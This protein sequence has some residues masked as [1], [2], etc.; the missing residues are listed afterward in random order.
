MQDN[1]TKLYTSSAWDD[2][3]GGD[4]MECLIDYSDVNIQYGTYVRG[5]IS[6][7]TNH[8]GSATDIEPSSG[9]WVTPFII[10]PVDPSVIYAGYE[11]I[12]KTTDRGNSWSTISSFSSGNFDAMAIAPSNNQVLY[13]STGSNIWVTVDG[14]S[15]WTNINSTLPLGSSNI[16]YIAV[17]GDDQN[18][19][20]VSLS[21]YNN[22]NVYE[23]TDGGSSWTNIS[24]GLPGIPAYSIVQNTQSTGEVQLY[25]GTELGVYFKKG[26]DN[27]VEFNTGLP[28]VKIGELEIFYDAIALNSKLYAATY[29][30]GLWVT[31]VEEPNND[32]ASITTS[33][34]ADITHNSATV[35]GEVVSEGASSVTERGIVW[36]LTGSP[37]TSDNKVI[38]GSVGT[39]SYT[40]SL[41]GL[42][43]ETTH[44]V[45]AYAINSHGT[46]YG[47]IVSFNTLS[48]TPGIETSNPTNITNSTATVGGDISY[49][50]ASAITE[51]G[52]VWNLTGDPTTSDNKIV[53]GSTGTGVF[54]V[55]MSGLSASTMY[56]VKAYASNTNGTSYGSEV[57]FMTLC[58]AIS[59]LPYIQNFDGFTTSSGPGCS[60]EEFEQEDCWMND[61]LNDETDW[62]PWSGSTSSS[63]TGPND[64]ISGGGNYLYTEASG[65][66]TNLTA[67]LLS[68][69][70]DFSTTDN[71]ELVFYYNMYGTSMGSLK[72]DLHYNGTWHDGINV[73]WG[74]IIASSISGNQGQGWNKAVADI[75]AADTYSDVQIRFSGTT[76]SSFTSDIALD[77]IEIRE[78]Y[79]CTPPSSQASGIVASDVTYNEATLS[80]TS[81]GDHVI[82]VAKEESAPS[83][84]PENGDSYAA[85]SIFGSGDNL[86]SGS[87]VIYTGADETVSITSLNEATEYYFAVYKYNEGDYCYNL[88]SPATGN[89]LTAGYCSSEATSIYDSRIDEVIINTINNNTTSDCATYSDFT[90]LSTDVE[91]G[92]TFTLSLTL[93][94]C[95]GDYAKGAKVYV[96]DINSV[97][98]TYTANIAIPSIF[99]G[100]VRM[101]IVCSETNDL[102][103]IE[104]CGE[105]YYGETEDYT[106]NVVN[107]CSEVLIEKQPEDTSACLGGNASFSVVATNANSYQ[108]FKD[109]NII[110]GETNNSFAVNN[111]SSNDEAD[112]TC[113][114]TGSCGSPV[115]TSIASLT[116]NTN[117]TIT[118]EPAS[119]EVCEGE[120]AE[121]T[122]VAAGT[123]LSYQWKKG[124]ENVGTN[125]PTLSITL[126]TENDA[127]DYS[128]VVSGTCNS[129]ES[130]SANLSLKI[131]TQI[132]TQPADINTSVGDDITFSVVA[133]GENLLYQW[134]FDGINIDG[135][136]EDSHQILSVVKDDAGEYTVTVSGDCGDVTSET[137]NLSVTT[138]I[139]ELSEFG[140]KV[141]PNPSEGIFN[142]QYS[143]LEKAVEVLIYSLDGKVVY[144]EKHFSQMNVINISDKAKGMYIVRF[145]FEDKSIVSNII[146]K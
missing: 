49:E 43:A 24:A 135:A 34:I 64:D 22:N 8:W 47:A 97:T 71:Q 21:G 38:D 132:T 126:V 115:T 25:V 58:D 23:S 36:N 108:W 73:N 75:S 7:T 110:D 85:N 77:N 103:F 72:I 141:Y 33:S 69:I 62:A 67:S 137:A 146:L 32:L 6:R 112:Y 81:D 65:S 92:Q 5:Q 18:T 140:I 11:E 12:Y 63:S 95:G 104:P 129:I 134:R 111:V 15:N 9:N 82:V 96:S 98:T 70:F 54:T 109:E 31:N 52:I 133:D 106:L 117:A 44:Y 30:R 40:T 136:N 56:Y 89:I 19:V 59:S 26:S 61:H 138:G 14:G 28:N 143:N 20:W 27:W 1:G 121:F 51:R 45:K 91:Q 37:T 17:K 4:G 131:A 122:I 53:E 142:I 74:G 13:V 124:T 101:R 128:C 84:T 119:I 88:I 100:S 80:W 66:C 130:N 102:S 39:G 116:L 93:G 107:E 139:Q 55:S 42:T 86:G 10:D 68:P 3:K 41:S 145:N 144:N 76:G 99:L 123:G 114:I 48:E 87:F 35:G 57:N 127:T 46:A 83:I 118:A 16:T 90:A 94:S 50:G 2:V 29:G 120:T 125:S 79:I 113:L 78:K 60:N 105:Y